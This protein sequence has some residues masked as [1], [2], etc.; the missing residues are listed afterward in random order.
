MLHLFEEADLAQRMQMIAD[1]L[2]FLVKGMMK[3]PKSYT[4]WFQ[5]QWALKKG[6][7]F[8]REL[9]TPEKILNS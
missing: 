2:K 3:S 7:E 8:E 1:E 5:R 6:L 4:L 9:V